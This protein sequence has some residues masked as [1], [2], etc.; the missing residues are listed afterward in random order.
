[1]ENTDLFSQQMAI[2][3]KGEQAVKNYYISKGAEVVDVSNDKE[4]QKKDI[5]LII[6][7]QAVEVKL[8]R[9]I[10]QYKELCIEIVSN[11]NP[12]YFRK[13]WF[14][15]SQA[16]ILI[17]Y[18]PA[19]KM[20]YQIKLADFRKYYEENQNRLKHIRVENIEFDTIIKPSI[21]SFVPIG[22]IEAN[23]TAYRTVSI[24]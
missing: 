8:G 16:D 20:M 12:G 15:T 4:Y 14:F 2:G 1:M 3:K 21:L 17:Y 6:N 24:E 9:K 22:D 5:D 10:P 7:G 18:S 13:G 23:I 11:D 19:E